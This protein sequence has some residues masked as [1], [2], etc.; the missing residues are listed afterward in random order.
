MKV[1]HVAGRTVKELREISVN[2]LLAVVSGALLSRIGGLSLQ[3]SIL[4]ILVQVVMA[5]RHKSFVLGIL[6]L[7]LGVFG[8][9]LVAYFVLVALPLDSIRWDVYLVIAAVTVPLF[10]TMVKKMTADSNSNL[11]RHYMQLNVIGHLIIWLV[12]ST[13]V[14]RNTVG[15][16][17]SWGED[18][19]NLLDS[20]SQI[21]TGHGAVTEQHLGGTGWLLT[22][23][24]GLGT[25]MV[26]G[27][28]TPLQTISG[29]AHLYMLA[30]WAVSLMFGLIVAGAWGAGSQKP[31]NTSSWFWV[32]T[33]FSFPWIAIAF[34]WGHI[35]SLMATATLLFAVG[36]STRVPSR[37]HDRGL[38]NKL[39]IVCLGIFAIG[40][41]WLPAGPV[42]L[43]SVLILILLN[44][45]RLCGRQ[46]S[47]VSQATLLISITAF[48]IF[49]L[50]ESDLT[51]RLKPSTIASLNELVGGVST[52]GVPLVGVIIVGFVMFVQQTH[53]QTLLPGA[54]LLIF[55]SACTSLLLLGFFQ[56]G[57]PQYGALKLLTV[58]LGSTAPFALRALRNK[59]TATHPLTVLAVIV[60][61]VLTHVFAYS[62]L[63][64]AMKVARNWTSV[65][66]QPALTLMLANPERPAVCLATDKDSYYE[67]Y[68]CSRLVLGAQG[69]Q[70]SDLSVFIGGN[71][72]L[73]DSDELYALDRARLAS[74]QVLIS[75]PQRLTSIDNCQARGWAGRTLPDSDSYVLGWLSAM[76]WG[77]VALWG[78]E[79][80]RVRP[81]FGYL[82]ESSDYSNY[83][84][85][86]LTRQL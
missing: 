22:P 27:T 7:V 4:V 16:V 13:P 53:K 6:P 9:A 31:S 75:S 70:S 71:L 43:V 56:S 10:S 58:V 40:G 44:V 60:G 32:G 3:A 23:V 80:S 82:R 35:N 28:T 41:M 72:C 36:I 25:L 46:N 14:A 5:V 59:V 76:P 69:L 42:A 37:M 78:Q 73:V 26:H 63:A 29:V 45:N 64:D 30:G 54:L 49:L 51:T 62:P 47:R 2:A 57:E 85:A 61:L 38:L 77:E 68:K 79:G 50:V 18:N 81:E 8:A 66:S 21:L 55:M 48:I 67:M 20:V 52:I 33:L 74:L 12:I 65:Q 11:S 19:A 86:W 17:Y 39:V 15:H 34:L 24:V 83:D 1:V 84:V